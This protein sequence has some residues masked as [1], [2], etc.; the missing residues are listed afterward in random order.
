MAIILVLAVGL[1]IG[2]LTY[3]YIVQ[4][5][6]K[7]DIEVCKASIALAAKSK[8]ELGLKKPLTSVKCNR[9]SWTFD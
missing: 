1:A 2:G 7:T 8:S 4:Q 6:H 9:H 5:K 3:K